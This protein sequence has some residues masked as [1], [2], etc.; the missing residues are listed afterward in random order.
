[1]YKGQAVC[2]E[3][4]HA[5]LRVEEF[6]QLKSEGHMEWGRDKPGDKLE[7]LDVFTHSFLTRSFGELRVYVLVITLGQIST[8]RGT[9]LLL[10]QP[11]AVPTVCTPY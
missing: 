10:Q 4:S 7:L 5:D 8:S 2:Q 3:A 9:S 6:S 1:M 11:C